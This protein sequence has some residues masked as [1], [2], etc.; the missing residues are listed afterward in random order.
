MVHTRFGWSR[1]RRATFPLAEG[2]F[3]S[4]RRASSSWLAGSA[5]GSEPVPVRLKAFAHLEAPPC[6]LE[7]QHLP[8]RFRAARRS[9][10]HFPDAVAPGLLMAAQP[11]GGPRSRPCAPRRLR[12]PVPC[13]VRAPCRPP[14]HR[15]DATPRWCWAPFCPLPRAPVIRGYVA[16]APPGC[17][18]P[19]PSRSAAP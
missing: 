16:V 6:R 4:A 19:S 5:G 3:P 9:R 7:G 10:R 1:G 2:E 14:W 11:P 15:R 13:C 18:S 12:W 8:R 17:F